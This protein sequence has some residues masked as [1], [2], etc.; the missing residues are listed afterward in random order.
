MDVTIP[1]PQ[2]SGRFAAVTEAA[3]P[4]SHGLGALPNWNLTDLY[5]SPTAP[6]I[7]QDL[8]HAAAA[9][10]D[11]RK[12]YEGKLAGL[13]AETFLKAIREYETIQE[14]LGKLMSYAQLVYAGNMAD[15]EL[16]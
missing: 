13:S 7:E 5:R 9:A 1:K 10:G 12:A 3:A 16:A 14:L 4:E 8:K 11:F 6:E 15:P 2:Q